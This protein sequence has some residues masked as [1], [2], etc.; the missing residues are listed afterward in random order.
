MNAAAELFIAKGIEATTVD[1]IALKAD[2]SKGTFYHY[3]PTKDDV[4]DSLRT[5]FTQD[6]LERVGAAVEACP[7]D[8]HVARLRCWLTT[9]ATL[10]RAGYDLHDVVFHQHG[11]RRGYWAERAAVTEQIARIIENGRRDGTWSVRRPEMAAVV[12]Y[13]GFHAIVD[14]AIEAGEK[15][16]DDAMSELAEL[17]G[18]MLAPRQGPTG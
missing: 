17:F 1:D 3:F 4:L 12:I 11:R 7:A 15:N 18:N 10:Y 2:A 16:V 13:N 14:E 9:A 5:R 6:F 8:D